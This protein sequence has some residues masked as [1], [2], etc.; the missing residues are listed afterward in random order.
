MHYIQS[1]TTGTIINPGETI[2]EIIP[3]EREYVAELRLAA[4]D[5]GRITEGQNITLKFTSYDFSKYGGIKTTLKSISMTNFLDNYGR[6]YFKVY[7]DLPLWYIGEE[8]QGLKILPG[9]TLTGEINV[10]TKS[11]LEYLV[12]P[13][14]AA[15]DNSFNES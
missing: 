12:V 3:V 2:F 4:K 14:K 15:K 1:R 5:R 6:A 10:G 7:V 8:K 11:L 9:M 13:V